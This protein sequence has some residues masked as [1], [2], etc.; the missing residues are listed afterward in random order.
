MWKGIETKADNGQ[1]RGA[2]KQLNNGPWMAI[3]I[4]IKLFF[5]FLGY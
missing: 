4:T 2:E 5:S 3:I 1:P